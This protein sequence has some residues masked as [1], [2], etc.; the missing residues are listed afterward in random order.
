MSAKTPTFKYFSSKKK[1]NR[2]EIGDYV[3]YGISEL[4]N[5]AGSSYPAMGGLGP[6]YVGTQAWADEDRK[7]RRREEYART[8]IGN[9][10]KP[11]SFQAKL[12]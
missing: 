5:I 4:R 8:I 6:S 1:Y 7:R 2:S 3:P 10:C 12:K 11:I 9:S